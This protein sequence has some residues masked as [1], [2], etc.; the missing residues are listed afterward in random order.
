MG[1]V[2]FL[3]I[4][5]TLVDYSNN[6]PESAPLAIAMA[7]ENGHKIYLCT[8]RSKAERCTEIVEQ[9]NASGIICANGAYIE[10]EDRILF[11]KTIPEETTRDIVDYL[12]ERG[13]EFYEETSTEVY[14]SENFLDQAPKKF[15]AYMGVDY[16][17]KTDDRK[18][19]ATYFPTMI[20]GGNVYRDDLIKISYVMNTWDD[21]F[22]TIKMFPGMRH[23]NWGGKTEVPSFGDMGVP[24]VS[25]ATAVEMILEFLGKT[26][27]DAFAFGDSEADIP[28]I[29]CVGT[30]VAM[31]NGSEAVKKV[32][33]YITDDVSNDG[34]KKAFEHFGLI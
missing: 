11:C 16:T 20:Y 4:D 31:G 12:H 34:L 30:G 26:R 2:I 15:A 29:E 27:E 10:S 9:T 28:M 17:E 18:L 23:G 6:L 14:A 13:L 32:S 5:G 7:R 22:D 19:I 24:E 25:K 21:Y 33:D 8:G 3:D 1:K